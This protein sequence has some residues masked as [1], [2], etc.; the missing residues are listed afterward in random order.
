[1]YTAEQLAAMKCAAAKCK[2]SQANG[3]TMYEHSDVPGVWHCGTH[4]GEFV[5]TLPAKEQTT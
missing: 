4:Y 5:A 3:H 1:M 2:K